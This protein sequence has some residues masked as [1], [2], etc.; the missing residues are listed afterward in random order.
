MSEPDAPQTTLTDDQQ[1]GYQELLDAA[2]EADARVRRMV[3]IIWAHQ[4]A[5]MNAQTLS[6]LCTPKTLMEGLRAA[7]EAED[8]R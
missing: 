5:R 6:R 8:V 3:G 2:D 4:T 7:M 1:R